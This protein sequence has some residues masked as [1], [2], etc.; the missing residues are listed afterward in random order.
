[1]LL[2]V[3]RS[4]SR[5]QH[6]TSPLTLFATSASAPATTPIY[7]HTQAKNNQN[8]KFLLY[9]IQCCLACIQKAIEVV[10][11]NAYI[12]VALKGG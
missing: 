9:C 11:R 4:A 7:A 6:R 12:F 5:H 1:M 2:R 10:T 8:L 3:D